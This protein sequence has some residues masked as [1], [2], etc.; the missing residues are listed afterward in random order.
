M[1]RVFPITFSIPSEKIISSI[2]IKK[3]LISP[4]IPGKLDTYIYDDE[5]TYYNHYKE[6]MFALTSKKAGWDCCRHYEILAC[7]TI[8][9]FIDIDDCPLETMFLFPKDYIKKGNKLY[10]IMKSYDFDSIPIPIINEYF[11]LLYILLEYTKKYL[12]TEKISMYILETVN[13]PN[14][15]KILYLSRD[16]YPD[17]LRCL[18][19]HGFKSI[20]GLNC[21]D[22]PKIP[23]I[24][25]NENIKYDQLYG[26]GI[27]Y[28]NLLNEN[29]HNGLENE[30][31]ILNN[32]RHRKYDLVIYGSY[33]RGMIYYDFIRNFYNPEEIVLLCGEDIHCCDYNYYT[34]QGHYVFVR[35]LNLS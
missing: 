3:K 2:P 30:E 22:F 18:T 4:L 6:C 31:D 5:E 14:I 16:L 32:I 10:E 12:T 1:H 21:T 19:L 9:I 8:P 13:K 28:T 26:K 7:G 34:M 25:K 35:E 29:L 15:Q 11:N 27:T 33:H 24:Y 17:Y 23:H 20:F